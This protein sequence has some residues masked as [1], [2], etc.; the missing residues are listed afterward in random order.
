MS[1]G[2]IALAGLLPHM[3]PTQFISGVRWCSGVLARHHR[4][5]DRVRYPPRSKPSSGSDNEQRAGLWPAPR[6]EKIKIV[7]IFRQMPYFLALGCERRSPASTAKQH[8]ATLSHQGIGPPRGVPG[9]LRVT[10]ER[11]FMQQHGL[12]GLRV[13]AQVQRLRLR[14]TPD[15]V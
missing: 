10:A 7:A 6:R 4:T 13:D 14:C 12:S 15:G 9:G 11:R 8:Q 2:T 5:F 1:R 3:P